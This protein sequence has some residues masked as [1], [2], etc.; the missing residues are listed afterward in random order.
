MEGDC[1]DP[2]GGVERLLHAV[3]MV[4]INVNVQNPLVVP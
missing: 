4:N 1:H 3:T 2:V